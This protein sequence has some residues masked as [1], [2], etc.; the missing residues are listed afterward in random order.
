MGIELSEDLLSFAGWSVGHLNRVVQTLVS[1]V[2]S[3]RGQYFDR[4][5]V[6]TQFIGNDDPR[7]AKLDNQFFEKP[8]CSLGISACLNKN[9]K[10]VHCPAVVCLQTMRGHLHRWHATASAFCHGS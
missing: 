3:I 6:T 5:D 4:F 2:V 8:L 7:L 9:I 10:N 1:A